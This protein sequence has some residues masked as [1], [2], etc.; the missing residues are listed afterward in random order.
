ML[1]I[2]SV[3]ET[4]LAENIGWTATNALRVDLALHCLQLDMTFH[5]EHTPGELIERIDGDVNQLANF[6]SRFTIYVTGNLL[7]L[8]G[9]LVVLFSI[10]WI[11]GIV[12]TAFAVVVLFTL[13]R[14]QTVTVPRFQQLRQARAELFGFLEEWIAGTEDIRAHGATEYA[15]R[16][17]YPL[18]STNLKRTQTAGV[19]SG[20]SWTATVL[21][22]ALG[23][24]TAL[25]LGISLLQA[26][27][28]TIGTVYLIFNYT[29]Q[30]RRPL[31]QVLRHLQDLQQASAS[32]SR[33]QELLAIRNALVDG[34]GVP[35]PQG[36]LSVEFTGVDFGYEGD[37]PIIKNISFSL[38]PG[39]KLGV[40][41]RTGSGKTTL[42]R[43]LFRLYDP[44]CGNIRLGGV[45]VREAQL[46]DLREHIGL[47]TQDVQI[48][49]ASVRDNLTFFDATIPTHRILQVITAL[50]LTEWYQALPEGLDTELA[51]GGDDLSA[52]EAQ[53]LALARVFLKDPGLIL[54]D[55]ASARLDPTTERLTERAITR[56]LEGR[57][58][59]VVAHRLETITRA[60]EIL[61]LDGGE[62]LEYGSRIALAQDPGSHFYRLLQIGR[63]GVSI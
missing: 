56:L 31:E 4:A 42:M 20:G 28:I 11:V 47:V 53:L 36:P 48:F 63:E 8:V 58:A 5:K 51:S 55:E 9:I 25:A 16:L 22:F 23:T 32:I 37:A 57:T 24:S 61:I 3:A 33:I 10:S 18:A 14:L 39:T 2:V 49:Q 62:I 7:L 38:E 35:I 45:D 29:E 19:A 46:L 44:D 1:Q 27:L 52:G 26:G 17:F 21:L 59:I 40:L 13:R 30:L 12:L 34:P 60:D 6:F 50:G 54:L 15:L 41:G 43:L